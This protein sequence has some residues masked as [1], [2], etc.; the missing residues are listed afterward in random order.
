MTKINP[1]DRLL[2]YISPSWALRRHGARMILRTLEGAKERSS[3]DALSGNRLR[4]DFTN[5]TKDADAVNVTN[6]QKLRNAV[7]DIETNTG[8]VAGPI[9]RIANNIIGHGITPQARVKE[10]GDYDIDDPRLRIT[11]EI[12]LKFNYQIEKAWSIQAPLFDSQLRQSIYELHKLSFMCRLRDGEVLVVLRSSLRNGRIVPLCAELVEIDRLA[13]PSD[14]ASDPKIRNGIEFDDEG[15]PVRYYILK[16]HPGANTVPLYR[17]DEFEKIDAFDS[18]GNRK[19]LHLYDILRPNQSRGFSPFAAALGDMQDIYKYREAKI[20]AARIQACLAAFVTKTGSW[21]ELSAK[22]TNTAGQKIKDFEPGMI[23][24]L[25]AGE[26]IT[27]H[28]PK[29]SEQQFKDIVEYLM[30]DAANAIDAPYELF[31][32]NWG[33]MNYSNARTVLLQAQLGFKIAQAYEITHFCQP[34]WNNFVT[35]CVVGGKVAAPN[36]K[37]RRNDYLRTMWVPPGWDW[38]DPQSESES[39]KIELETGLDTFA[40]KYASRG[41]DWEEQLEQRAM[42]LKKIK[43]LEKKYDVKFPDP[44]SKTPAPAESV[45]GQNGKNGKNGQNG[46]KPKEKEDE[47]K[48]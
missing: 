23:E 22:S 36:F 20:V 9:K 43:Y 15:V 39:A 30:R 14:R 47:D 4:S 11:S 46:K 28:D 19:V 29:S 40:N 8:A 27:I 37:E 12:A 10:D 3:Y 33:G 5:I 34:V 6:L 31:S 2:A 42:E 16:K 32:G 48:K 13:T 21:N 1:L 35:D 24:Y 45:S 17:P 38:V 41:K 18:A 7:R 25:N 26:S 44:Y